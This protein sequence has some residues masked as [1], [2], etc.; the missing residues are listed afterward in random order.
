[1]PQ[2]SPLETRVKQK[3]RRAQHH[4]AAARVGAAE[5]EIRDAIKLTK[6]KTDVYLAAVEINYIARASAGIAATR[7]AADFAGELIDRSDRKL[8]DRTLTSQEL[9]NI[10]QAYGTI[11]FDLQR[12]NESFR[13]LERAVKLWPD[14]P[15]LANDLG[16]LY[17]EAD[18][19]LDK[20]LQLT[21]R[22]V[23]SSPRNG[24]Y[25]DSLGWVYYKL[26]RRKEAVRELR[27]AVRL[28][29]DD[30]DLRYHLGMA[31]IADGRSQ[32][33]EVEFTKAVACDG[34][35][36]GAR[37]QLRKLKLPTKQNMPK[38]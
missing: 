38:A 32:E 13:A 24:M 31:Y 14:N 3:L 17:A 8:L 29:P 37:E 22:A 10:L 2:A 1:M 19:N 35:H 28:M 30:P 7:L 21:R 33:A 27:R 26:G 11:S 4:L 9:R 23:K 15:V 36:S 16:Y 6:H 18:T 12:R 25:I 5:K 20:A 34:F